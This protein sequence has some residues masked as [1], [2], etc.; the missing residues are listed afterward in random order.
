MLRAKVLVAAGQRVQEL[1]LLLLH[2]GEDGVHR[3]D[4]R[5]HAL[6]RLAH[7]QEVAASEYTFRASTQIETASRDFDWFNRGIFISVAGRHAGG[8]IY[9]TYL[10]A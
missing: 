5:R 2:P 1:P 3:A 6:V 7:G 8:V 10:V 9:E 4:R